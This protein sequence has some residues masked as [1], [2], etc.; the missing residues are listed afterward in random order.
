MSKIQPL[1]E[2][3]ATTPDFSSIVPLLLTPLLQIVFSSRYVVD[4]GVIKVCKESLD[5]LLDRI[6]RLQILVAGLADSIY[7]TFGRWVKSALK[8][9]SQ[10]GFPD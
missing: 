7:T 1:R 5:K 3:I 8:T 10:S 9:P 4:R 6:I 2:N